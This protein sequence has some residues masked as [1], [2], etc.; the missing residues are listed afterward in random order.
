VE[1]AVDLGVGGGCERVWTRPARLLTK[2]VLLQQLQRMH[3][4][5]LLLQPRIGLLL[6]I[7]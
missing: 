6:G 2:P 5:L 4:G 3:A 1:T 7:K